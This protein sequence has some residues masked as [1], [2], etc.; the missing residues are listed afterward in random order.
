VSR[1]DRKRARYVWGIVRR[2]PTETA[3]A[4][5]RARRRRRNL[6]DDEPELLDSDRLV[7]EGDYEVGAEALAASAAVVE[8]WERGG[9]G[10]I[11]SLEWLLPWFHLVYGGGVHTVLRFADH[12]ARR[13][14]VE[15]R[16]RV[17]DRA[18]E[19][20]AADVAAK[21]AGAFPALA[22]AP[23][24]PAGTAPAEC[25]AA[26]ATA[27]TSA[28]PLVRHDRTRAKFFFVQDFEP[29]FHP[30]GAARAVLDEAGRLGLPGIVNTPGLADVYRSLG[31]RAVAFTPAVDTERY[32]P[33]PEPPAEA[34]VRIVFYGRPSQAR[35][36][37]GLGLAALRLVKRRHGDAVEIVCAGEDW[38][39][40]QYGAADVLSN[41]GQL[42]SLD[43][44]A[45]LYRS[46]AVGLCFML[47]PHPSYQPLEYMASG[48]ATVS[49]LNQHTGWLLRH[50]RNC[51]LAPPLP[52]LVAEQVGRLVDD[53]GLRARI[54]AA[55]REEVS[56]V[57]WE[58]E[59]ERVWEAMTSRPELFTR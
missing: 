53:P 18:G 19:R 4:W 33:G 10:P 34:P 29:A 26:I 9:A 14:G 1:L 20:A 41:L 8:R 16:F 51:L 40:G 44:V 31:N 2:G 30:A 15:N 46:C 27:W 28:F 50:E 55:G 21:I 22:D 17:Y 7:L 13:H 49:N 23:V 37:F 52:A 58:D 36:A 35:N 48:V 56:R 24:T 47:T 43:A 59:F 38:N 54:A 6:A 42:E 25:D 12:V 57:R 39:P 11:A 32:R 3:Y 45:D 5:L